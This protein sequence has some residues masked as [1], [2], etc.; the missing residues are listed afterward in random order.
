MWESVVNFH[1]E[2][3]H[4]KDRMYEVQQGSITV[5]SLR[6]HWPSYHRANSH[7]Q[8]ALTRAAVN[9]TD[10]EILQVIDRIRKA[11][12]RL[13]AETQTAFNNV[14]DGLPASF[15][16]VEMI[17]ASVNDYQGDLVFAIKKRLP[18]EPLTQYLEKR[19]PTQTDP[20]LSS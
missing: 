14:S 10:P 11:C 1:V 19:N 3:V 4:F 2:V 20:D 16:Q 9:I 6:S 13:L 12:D 7:A 15:E 18:N 8:L 5:D 17:L